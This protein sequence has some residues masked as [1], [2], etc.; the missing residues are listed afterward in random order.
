MAF[1][2][3]A[4]FLFVI[5]TIIEIFFTAPGVE[6]GTRGHLNSVTMWTLRLASVLTLVFFMG[7]TYGFIESGHPI[8]GEIEERL[9]SSMQ[10]FSFD[11]FGSNRSHWQF[12]RGCSLLLCINIAALVPIL[13]T[14]G[15]DSVIVKC[16]ELVRALVAVIFMA[17]N[18]IAYVSWT[19]FFLPPAAITT[20]VSALLG[21]ALFQLSMIN[22]I[23][24]GDKKRKE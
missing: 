16:P 23:R 4:L 17:F 22:P 14:L 2:P 13:W 7:H 18:A 21:L 3:Q 20:L 8:R 6:F 11:V 5:V 9:F 10:S 12:Y 24:V 15:S 19:Y 1:E